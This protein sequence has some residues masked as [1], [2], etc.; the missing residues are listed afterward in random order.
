[1]TPEMVA[2]LRAFLEALC[3][4]LASLFPVMPSLEKAFASAFKWLD[5]AV[6]AAEQTAARA[7]PVHAADAVPVTEARPVGARTRRSG[8]KLRRQ[9]VDVVVQVIG[10][11]PGQ[12][13]R[14][15]VEPA[16]VGRTSRSAVTA[17]RALFAK[18]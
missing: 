5:K 6:V 1:M 7:A 3:A 18:S 16:A 8:Q 10:F 13:A 17:G 2:R 4:A 9:V 12:S 14:Q 15:R 11:M